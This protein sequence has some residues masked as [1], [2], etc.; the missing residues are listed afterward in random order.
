MEPEHALSQTQPTPAAAPTP[1][2]RWRPDPGLIIS[3][4]A[5][6]ASLVTTVLSI[7]RSE[8]Q[9]VNAKK[10]ALHTIIQ[11]YEN[12][13]IHRLEINKTESRELFDLGYNF[14]VSEEKQDFSKLPA[15]Q[16]RKISQT[17]DYL[18]DFNEHMAFETK[19]LA[20]QALSKAN[21][22]DDAASSVDL[23]DAAVV[24]TDARLANFPEH[25]YRKALNKAGN[26]VE[27]VGAARGLAKASYA[28]G[29]KEDFRKAIASALQVFDK[30]PQE[31]QNPDDVRRTHFQ[32]YIGAL[33]MLGADDCPHARDYF[34][35]AEAQTQKPPGPAA[36][37]DAK[38]KLAKQSLPECFPPSK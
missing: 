7:Q 8:V 22:L 9:D 33:D 14:S 2:R 34:A 24:M 12:N 20:R 5:F 10:D 29:R 32:T 13:V 35:D 38:L 37:L 3:A 27:Y 23:A 21:E 25:L 30:F 28:D 15:Q 19:T 36:D 31:A 11:Q 17:L 1:Y 4:A 16:A 18:K 26:S 6:F